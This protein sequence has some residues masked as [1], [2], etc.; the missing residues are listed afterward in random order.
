MISCFVNAHNSYPNYTIGYC[1]GQLMI[2]LFATLSLVLSSA[3][4]FWQLKAETGCKAWTKHATWIFVLL[5]TYECL[6]FYKYFLYPFNQLNHYLLYIVCMDLL[7]SMIIYTVCS[8]FA[9][10]ASKSIPN[11]SAVPR[12][13]NLLLIP[14]VGIY[15]VLSYFQINHPSGKGNTN[16]C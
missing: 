16:Q 7:Q 3:L 10:A 6:V 12:Y 14:V 5:V 13:L 15:A 8:L 1:T 9:A 2:L 4:L 11:L